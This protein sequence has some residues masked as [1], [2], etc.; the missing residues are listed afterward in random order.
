MKNVANE[1]K[2]QHVTRKET[3]GKR[4]GSKVR[5]SERQVDD[6]TTRAS[7]S[8]VSGHKAMGSPMARGRLQVGQRRS[9][10][11]DQEP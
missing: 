5:G 3:P 8:R 4:A 2:L 6:K 7:V 10:R 1:E 11:D 9:L